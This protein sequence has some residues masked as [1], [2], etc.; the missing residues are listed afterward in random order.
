MAAECVVVAGRPGDTIPAIA[1]GLRQA[2][3]GYQVVEV[4]RLADAAE[5]VRTHGAHVL[6]MVVRRPD[7]P[8]AI[9]VCKSVRRAET[10]Q[11]CAI[12]AVPEDFH[13]RHVSNLL[14][15]GA[16]GY[17]RLD[18][19]SMELLDSTVKAVLRRC[20]SLRTV[21]TSGAM[22]I[23]PA[24]RTIDI[25]G[26]TIDF[27]KIEFDVLLKIV[28]NRGQVVGREELRAMIGEVQAE[29]SPPSDDHCLNQHI[30]SIRQKL[31]PNKA[32]LQTVRGIGYKF[33]EE[34][35]ADLEGEGPS[36]MEASA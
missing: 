28:A 4:S 14:D 13:A 18:D 25:D 9:G 30:H 3:A 12:L 21:I 6:L 26:T 2:P 24:E 33:D 17:V 15:A 36:Q 27:T 29:G 34:P 19:S 5:T 22:R 35:L 23:V 32:I 8:A 7:I 11:Q 16:D 20:H 1:S 31:G 10:V